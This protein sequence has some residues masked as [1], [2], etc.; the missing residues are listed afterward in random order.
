MSRGRARPRRHSVPKA[1]FSITSN[2]QNLR[3]RGITGGTEP[4]A[5]GR[6]ERVPAAERPHRE[7]GQRRVLDRGRDLG[8][9]ARQAPA[10]R[11]RR[12]GPGPVPP[13]A[14][15]GGCLHY[16]RVFAAVTGTALKSDAERAVSLALVPLCPTVAAARPSY[17]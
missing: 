17:S 8:L 10:C 15:I 16:W 14:G 7:P 11:G 4:A 13:Y 2:S 12:R 1:A 3:Q 9:A 5:P 6:G